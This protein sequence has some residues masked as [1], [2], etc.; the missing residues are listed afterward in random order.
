MLG[1]EAVKSFLKIDFDDDD[2]LLTGLMSASE[3][4]LKNA[5]GKTFSEENEL[6]TLYKL[7]LI[8]EW[9]SNRNLVEGERKR[10][11]EKVRFTLQSVL[12]QLIYS[13]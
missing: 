7:V 11:S 3:Q 8:N 1:L 2:V 6:A 10:V 12:N 9:Y 4:Y 5:T 13:E